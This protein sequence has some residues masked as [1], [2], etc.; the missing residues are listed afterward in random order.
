MRINKPKLGG[1]KTKT[2]FAFL[3]VKINKQIRWM[4]RVTV[5]FQRVK[6]YQW[7]VGEWIESG[8]KW[9]KIEFI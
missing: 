7:C 4:E 5:K 3:P 6:A 2:W 1:E 9:K 8:E